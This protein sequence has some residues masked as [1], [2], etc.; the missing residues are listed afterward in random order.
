MIKKIFIFPLIL[1]TII[2]LSACTKN[3]PAANQDKPA[4]GNKANELIDAN[5]EAMIAGQRTVVKQV[6][7]ISKDEHIK[8]NIDAP[9]QIIVY[10]DFECPFSASFND[11][12]DQVEKDY[13]DKV[14][15]AYR[16]YP[17]RSHV[18]AVPAAIAGECAAE[19]GKF[20]E[21]YGKLFSDNRSGKLDTDQFIQDATDLKLDM[22]KFRQCQDS[23]K[24]MNKIETQMLEG[25]NFGVSGT[26][27]IFVNGVSYSGAYPYEDFQSSD[28]QPQVGMKKIIENILNK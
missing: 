4:G 6:R 3:K 13:K 21:M 8:G 12:L 1:I 23:Q 7:A 28:G 10:G 16:H 24:Y 26:P 11:T 22:V 9:V 27:G 15:I 20:W 25:V 14:V 17:L 19:Q 2:S 18:M 5:Q